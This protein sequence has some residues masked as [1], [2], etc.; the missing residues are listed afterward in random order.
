M[1]SS[2]CSADYETASFWPKIIIRLSTFVWQTIRVDR[3]VQQTIRMVILA[4]R[5]SDSTLC[6]ANYQTGSNCPEDHHTWPLGPADIGLASPALRAWRQPLVERPASRKHSWKN[7]EFQYMILKMQN[8]AS[9]LKLLNSTK[10]INIIV[11]TNLWV[12]YWDQYP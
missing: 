7:V 10:Y 2:L 12:D 9:V 1:T 4:R 11:D 3:F 5:L 6:P 8:L